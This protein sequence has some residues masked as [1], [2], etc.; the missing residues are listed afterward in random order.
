MPGTGKFEIQEREIVV[1]SGRVIC[2]DTADLSMND[3]D[4][5]FSSEEFPLKARD[6]YKELR[7]RGYDYGPTFQGIQEASITGMCFIVCTQ[8]VLIRVT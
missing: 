5:D 3:E 2:P 7:L 1:A 6:V 8:Y 4:F